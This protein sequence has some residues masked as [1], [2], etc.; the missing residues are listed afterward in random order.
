MIDLF[1]P[2]GIT[3]HKKELALDGN[4]LFFVGWGKL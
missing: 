3:G 2:F 1:A 4:Q